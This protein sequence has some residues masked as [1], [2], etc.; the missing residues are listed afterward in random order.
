MRIK[1]TGGRVVH[2]PLSFA[3]SMQELGGSSIQKY[4][5]LLGIYSPDRSITPY[6]LKPGLVVQDPDG[7]TP[8][9]D[10]A[11][12]M[13]NVVWTLRLYKGSTEETLTHGKTSE[14]AA[15]IQ[16]GTLKD[17]YTDDSNAVTIY[18]NVETG[19]L[20]TA[21]FRGDYYNAARKE[22]SHFTWRKDIT[23]ADETDTDISLELRFPSKMNFSPFKYYGH[24]PIEA[25]LR[26][27]EAP[28]AAD[29]AQYK[30]QVFDYTTKSWND[31]VADDNLWYVSG[32]D[33]STIVVDVDF[34]QKV[35][36][37]V[38][39][40]PKA[41]STL[42]DSASTL[43]RRW[44]GQYDDTYEFAYSMYLFSST[45]QTKA[46]A[47]V[48]NRQGDISD[49]QKYFDI[50]MFYRE[51]GTSEWQS[52]G[53]GTEFTIEREQMAGDHQIGGCCRELSAYMPIELPD[54]TILAD[55]EGNPIVGRFPTTEIET[56]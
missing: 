35:A 17:Y 19:E 43:L 47:K 38:T 11:T 20:L 18:R 41:D 34:I 9:G 36:L 53:N 10:Y 15:D 27:G 14:I 44:Y 4:N 7:I 45:R 26:N 6:Q 2:S 37:R 28:L 39:G 12:S 24:F 32:K 30:W 50:Q 25:V 49:P 1:I 21:D 40:W 5:T 52:L 56:E 48:T 16:A 3:F 54:G 42:H 22:T 29:K 46:V 13:T 23:T 51:N 31:I 55:S 33:S 8:T